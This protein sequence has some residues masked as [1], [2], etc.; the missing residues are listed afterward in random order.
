MQ[1]SSQ[2]LTTAIKKKFSKSWRYTKS[3][4]KSTIFQKFII[5]VEQISNPDISWCRFKTIAELFSSS[6]LEAKNRTGSKFSNFVSVGAGNC[7]FEVSMAKNLVDTG[8]KDF[9]FECLEINPVMLER[10][11]EIAR[12]N[13]VLDNHAFC[14]SWFQYLDSRQKNTTA[15]WLIKRCTT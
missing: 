15:L 2:A 3:G 10:G 4:W 14:G 13:G 11:K 8:F 1:I 6:F 5:M 12:E 9:I 7:D